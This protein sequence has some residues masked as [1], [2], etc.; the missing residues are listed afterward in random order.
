MLS[1]LYI[2]IFFIISPVYSASAQVLTSVCGYK[3]LCLLEVTNTSISVTAK[4]SDLENSDLG[5]WP[6]DCIR[7]FTSRVYRDGKRESVC[8]GGGKA[9][10]RECW[11][12]I[13][14]KHYFCT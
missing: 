14:W 7:R 11:I 5:T 12:A 13:F 4:Q 6:L 10:R 1:I 8:W 3:G 9:G 2:Y